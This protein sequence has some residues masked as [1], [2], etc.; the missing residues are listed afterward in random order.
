MP[1]CISYINFQKSLCFLVGMYELHSDV[2]WIRK[3]LQRTIEI[4]D[5]EGSLG[6][7]AV[8]G[9]LY[10]EADQ[11]YD[12]YIEAFAMERKWNFYERSGVFS[13][14]DVGSEMQENRY[15]RKTKNS[16]SDCLLL[17]DKTREV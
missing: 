17:C 7:T 14:E 16:S 15:L 13:I 12:S 8:I 11:L 2:G 1:G 9:R 4:C 6:T 3:L 5:P 10:A